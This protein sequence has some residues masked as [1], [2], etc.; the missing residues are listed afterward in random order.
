ME[1]IES[2]ELEILIEGKVVKS[3]LDAF[4]TQLKEVVKSLSRNLVTDDDFETADRDAKFLKSAEQ[5]LKSAK[6]EALKQAEGIQKLFAAIDDVS[7]EA[8]QAR[9][10]LERQIKTRKDERRKEILD[11]YEAQIAGGLGRAWRPR[12]DAVIKG[13]K[14]FESIE[15]AVIDELKKL[16]EQIHKSQSLLDQFLEKHGKSLIPDHVALLQKPSEELKTELDRRVERAEAEA[17]R[18]RIEEEKRQ[19]EAEKLAAQKA[20]AESEAKV[21]AEE[22]K[23]QEAEPVIKDSLPTEPEPEFFNESNGIKT[24]MVNFSAEIRIAF[25]AVREARSELKYSENIK[26]AEQFAAE[27]SAAYS[28]LTEGSAK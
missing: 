18:K 3:N 5:S 27:L 8:R 1:T 26:K 15:N 16:N 25:V 10:G 12:L 14:S 7:E 22:R 2:T 4:C 28:R 6:E 21:K 24:E 17:E 11:E 13:K 20:Q 19:L 23:K 9:L